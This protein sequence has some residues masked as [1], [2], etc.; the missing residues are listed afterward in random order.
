M[1]SPMQGTVIVTFLTLFF[2]VIVLTATGYLQMAGVKSATGDETTLHFF[3]VASKE[4]YPT[5]SKPYA[6]CSTL[7][8]PLAADMLKI[9]VGVWAHF[10][11]FGL[12]LYTGLF[13]GYGWSFFIISS[14]YTLGWS[15]V[16][17]ANLGTVVGGIIGFVSSRRCMRS[18][19]ERKVKSFP[20]SWSRRIKFFTGE[21]ERSTV[22]YLLVS[23]TMR[24]SNMLTFGMC[25]GMCAGEARCPL[26]RHAWGAGCAGKPRA[27][28]LRRRRGRERT[29]SLLVP[30]FAE[31]PLSGWCTPPMLPRAERPCLL[32]SRLR[33]C[34]LSLRLPPP[35]SAGSVRRRDDE[36]QLVR[37]RTL[38]ARHLAAHYRARRL[39]RDT[40]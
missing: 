38:P 6:C 2:T 1:P 9:H 27:E 26:G 5:D 8:S 4:Q 22:A 23:G 12:F 7:A 13:F 14:G 17:T 10:I 24:N 40:R 30:P 19:V 3:V 21:I 28:G 20:G 35:A 11:F 31:W 36:C 37:V 34:S 39:H 33:S 32:D 16:I 29:R 15:A 25:N 18:A